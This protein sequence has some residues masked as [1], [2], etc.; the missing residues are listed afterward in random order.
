MLI[1][2]QWVKHIDAFTVP[3]NETFRWCQNQYTHTHTP[4]YI[5]IHSL[6]A[7]NSHSVDH[8]F[9]VASID[10]KSIVTR[11]SNTYG[12]IFSWRPSHRRIT[13]EQ[14]VKSNCTIQS[15]GLHFYFLSLSTRIE[16]EM[17]GQMS[18]DDGNRRKSNETINVSSD[19]G[20]L[21]LIYMGFR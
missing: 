18:F 9:D 2:D 15:V 6:F 12:I 8:D 19:A 14:F 5:S 16:K 11:Y 21:A 4:I 1:S 13:R 10:L 20:T 3:I 7:L 17:R